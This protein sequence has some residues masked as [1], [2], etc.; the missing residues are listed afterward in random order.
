V[1][2]RENLKQHRWKWG[3]KNGWNNIRL[4][5]MH[6]FYRGINCGLR[7][8]WFG[9]KRWRF[10]NMYCWIRFS[11]FLGI[12]E[13]ELKMMKIHE[14]GFEWKKK[15]MEEYEKE[16]EA[17]WKRRRWKT[18]KKHLNF[19]FISILFPFFTFNFFYYNFWN[20]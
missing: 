1:W 8:V 13:F 19:I 12:Y 20:V 14:F 9:I 3:R 18:L 2:E 16:E 5:V 11:S 17:R 4:L 6:F 7:F 15:N 10:E